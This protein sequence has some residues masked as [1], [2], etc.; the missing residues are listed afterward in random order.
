M[1]RD[2]ERAAA[3]LEAGRPDEASVHAWNA[4]ATVTPEEAPE[5]ARIAREV[6]DGRL[7]AELERRGLPTDP[8]PTPEPPAAP[9]RR[10]RFLRVLPGLIFPL[11]FVAL[12]I[13]VALSQSVE[14]GELTPERKDA[15]SE[16]R[17][18][19]PTLVE[20]AGVWLVPVGRC[21]RVDVQRLADE[22]SIRYRI[23]VGVLPGVELPRWTLAVDERA[24]HADRLLVL[25]SRAYGTKGRATVIGVTD[26]DMVVG[27]GEVIHPFALRRPR[28]GI[29][30]TSSLGANVFDILRGHTRHERT[31]KLVARL[32]GFLYLRRPEVDDA[33]S[34]LR[35]EMHSA[36]DIDEL[37]EVL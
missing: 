15:S 26:F 19:E 24:L 35:P 20:N 27:A 28:Y 7:L 30:S 37:D 36:G 2:L 21:T 4:L 23:P 5:L 18:E 33:H 3:A 14:G 9:R 11:V 1:S 13:G 8:P 31:R 25:L 16:Y 34:L 17:Y 29:V 12:A 32:I 10:R 22:I 6:G